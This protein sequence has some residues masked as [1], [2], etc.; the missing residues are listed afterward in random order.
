[1]ELETV[2]AVIAKCICNVQIFIN[3]RHAA[4]FRPG[5]PSRPRWDTV[6]GVEQHRRW[7]RSVPCSPV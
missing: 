2:P 5:P 1:M 4:Q 7:A 6:D 3:A